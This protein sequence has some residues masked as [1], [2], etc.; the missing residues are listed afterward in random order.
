M[1]M[2][3]ELTNQFL[4]AGTQAFN[5]VGKRKGT[6]TMDR[7]AIIRVHKPQ[8]PQLGA[9]IKIS[10]ARRGDFQKYLGQAVG[11]AEVGDFL[12]ERP[13]VTQEVFGIGRKN[14]RDEFLQGVLVFLIRTGP[15]RMHHGFPRCL[16]KIVLQSFD[17]RFT[18]FVLQRPNAEQSLIEEVFFVAVWSRAAVNLLLMPRIQLCPQLQT[19]LPLIRY[20]RQNVDAG[21]D[22]FA[23]LGIVRRGCVEAMWPI[24][25]PGLAER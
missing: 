13:E 14:F 22:A 18:N 2:I 9:L 12:L 3:D 15:T 1:P 24:L 5:V 8:V 20:L 10:G 7:H 23:A 25:T 11:H 17:Q 19:G 6:E 21:P 16:D 4:A